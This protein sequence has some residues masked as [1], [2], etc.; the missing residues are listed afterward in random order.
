MKKY[1]SAAALLT[2]TLFY[3]SS[4]SAAPALN[5]GG[6]SGSSPIENWLDQGSFSGTIRAYDFDRLYGSPQVPN[7]SAFSVAGIFNLQ[8]APILNSFEAGIS[9][10]TASAL[11]LNNRSRTASSF[12][13]LDTTLMGPDNDLTALGQAYVQYK[14][15]WILIR[16]GDQELNTPWV[17]ASD[18]RV[19]PATYQAVFGEVTPMKSLHLFGFR[20]L[21][22]KSRTSSTY[23]QDNLYYPS[24]FD[25]DSSFGGGTALNGDAPKARGTLAVGANYNA[26]GLKAEAWYYD[27]YDFAN[28]FYSDAK[29]TLDTGRGIRPYVAGQFLREWDADSL[30]NADRFGTAIDGVKGNGVNATAFGAQV[31]LDYT[32]NSS[33]FG[34]GNIALSYNSLLSHPGSIGGGAIVS[35]YTIGYG[36][37]PLYTTALI[38]GLVELGPGDAK[39]IAL[40][41]HL[42]DNHILAVLAFTRFDTKL[43]G[44]SND[45]YVDIIYFPGGKFEGLSIRDR[46]EVSNASF[47]LNNGATGNQGH[48]FIYNRVMLQYN[49]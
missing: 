46:M 35:P 3:G 44:G 47:Q 26:N 13:H 14:K 31:G 17:G 10:F 15:P 24:T 42:F 37:D 33:A 40:S 43:N 29:Y 8:S 32:L 1:L 19:L 9:L 4:A 45:T 22:F 21:A 25:G 20:Q 49:F 36:T 11:G 30:L 39:R 48:S 5:S 41:Q 16:V 6:I 28:M 2:G 18:S 34:E 12:P 23:F 38:R 27:F 7:Q